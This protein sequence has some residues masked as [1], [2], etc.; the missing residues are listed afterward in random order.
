MARYYISNDIRFLTGV[1]E[2]TT[3]PS[4]GTHMKRSKAEE[5]VKK[6]QRY[7]YYKERSSN[8]G[9]DYVICTPMKF[10]G[11]DGKPTNTMKGARI[12]SSPEDA[13]EYMDTVRESLDPDLCIVMDEKF[14]RKNRPSVTKEPVEPLSVF[15]YANMDSTE[16]I[17]IPIS[18]KEE[19]YK[20]S[21]GMCYLC[22]KPLSKYTYTI[23][24]IKP[25]S[26]GGTNVPENLRAVH[27]S[28]NKLKGNFTDKELMAGVSNMYC[29]AVSKNPYS[30]AT[31]MF[32]RSFVRGVIRGAAK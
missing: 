17:N 31:V 13:F 25:L 11:I 28:C 6:D 12:F 32:M 7:R 15:R 21:N 20:R 8:K 14:S 3:S 1:R 30:P 19:I 24:H 4:S 26:R 23:D 2:A 10:L 27:E 9:N 16:R 5:F 18:V 22:G 29:N